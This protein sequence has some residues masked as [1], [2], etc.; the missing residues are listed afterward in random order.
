MCVDSVC[1]MIGTETS[2][3]GRIWGGTLAKPGEI[4]WQLLVKSPNRGGASLINDQWA[5]TAAHVV[6]GSEQASL[7]FYGR[8]LD[9]KKA[10]DQ[11]TAVLTTE[12]III[13]PDYRKGISADKQTNFDNDIAL[14][15]FSSRVNLGPN[16]RPICLPKENRGL[17]E[18]ELGTVSGWG[19]KE[20]SIKSRF[21]QYAHVSVYPQDDCEDTPTLQ[22]NEAGVF[23]DNMFCAGAQGK[24]SCYG[25]SGGPFVVPS[26]LTSEGPYHLIG[27]VSWGASCSQQSNKGYYTKVENYIRWIKETI[28]KEK[29]S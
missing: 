26:L 4:P 20:T 10:A 7:T 3:A 21:L 16:L 18:L 19:Q 12:K 22:S 15:K 8:L 24:D 2:S 6:D 17:S 23:T 9:G 28:E 14:I 1:G 11:N 27:I 29:K 13:H 5:V 25:D